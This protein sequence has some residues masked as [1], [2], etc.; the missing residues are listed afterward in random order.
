M[1]FSPDKGESGDDESRA[2]ESSSVPACGRRCA[3]LRVLRYRRMFAV[4]A[5]RRKRGRRCLSSERHGWVVHAGHGRDLRA[6]HPL[7]VPVQALPVLDVPHLLAANAGAIA[8]V[9]DRMLGTQSEVRAWNSPLNIVF[10]V[11]LAAIAMPYVKS[12]GSY[13]LRSHGACCCW[14]ISLMLQWWMGRERASGRR[15]RRNPRVSILDQSK[16][17]SYDSDLPVDRQILAFLANDDLA[18]SARKALAS[19]SPDIVF[20]GTRILDSCAVALDRITAQRLTG[21]LAMASD[22]GDALGAARVKR[23]IDALTS[24]QKRCDGLRAEQAALTKQMLDKEKEIAASDQV[25]GRL[26]RA[27]LDIGKSNQLSV[28]DGS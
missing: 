4:D 11:L 21:A 1:R 5:G 8:L 27:W 23:Q 2:A 3:R 14:R 24:M 17:A 7:A 10:N 15:A 18:A 20:I 12:N 25:G 28:D 26:M 13:L 22:K 9:A 19:S 6:V 16:A